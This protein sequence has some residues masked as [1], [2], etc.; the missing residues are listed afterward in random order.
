MMSRVVRQAA[1][2]AWTAAGRAVAGP[3]R[4]QAQPLLS[5][6]SSRRWLATAA[7]AGDETAAK[8]STRPVAGKRAVPGGAAATATAAA[9][10]GFGVPPDDFFDEEVEKE[11]EFLDVASALAVEGGL[12]NLTTTSDPFTW[13]EIDKA[14]ENPTISLSKNSNSGGGYG[15]NS[16]SSSADMDA[17][18]EEFEGTGA[19]KIVTEA[20]SNNDLAKHLAEIQPRTLIPEEYLNYSVPWRKTDSFPHEMLDQFVPRTSKELFR[21]D[22]EGERACAGKLQRKGHSGE[23]RC[24]LVDLDDLNHLDVLTLRRFIADDGEILGKKQTGLCSKCQRF[25]AT[26]VKRARNLGILPHLS[27]FV[28]HD[29]KPLQKH[30]ATF[31]D[32][33]G[34]KQAAFSRTIK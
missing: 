33:V 20:L 15:S 32:V 12:E 4:V 18:A 25:V 17:E 8:K 21:H 29:S 5:N 31:H 26:T 19:Y 27:E 34:G 3:A 24:H 1:P 2:R 14:D 16:N 28:V 30:G 23:L 10:G 22:A 9:G 6:N 13:E 7:S 11:K